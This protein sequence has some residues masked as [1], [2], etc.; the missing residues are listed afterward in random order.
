MFCTGT[1]PDYN[2]PKAEVECKFTALQTGGC[3][4]QLWG[5]DRQD[6][7]SEGPGQV[8]KWADRDPIKF[9]KGRCKVLLLGWPNAGPGGD[10][11]ALLMRTWCSW[12]TLG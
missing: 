11:A 7:Y 12:L 2:N 8:E 3:S 1:C 9:S 10:S 6:C 4:L 5:Q